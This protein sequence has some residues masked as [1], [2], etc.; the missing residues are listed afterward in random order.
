MLNRNKRLDLARG[1]IMIYIVTIIHGVY[2]LGFGQAFSS[3]LLFEMPIVFII[4]GYAYAIYAKKNPVISLRIYFRYAQTRLSRI[5]IP[6]FVYAL[7]CAIVVSLVQ[8]NIH[9][10]ENLLAWLNPF[11][12]GQGHSISSLSWHLWFI[13]PF[14][15]VTLFLPVVTHKWIRKLPLILGFLLLCFFLYFANWYIEAKFSTVVFYF[16]WAYVGFK[17]GGGLTITSNVLLAVIAIASIMLAIGAIFMDQS[18]NMQLNKFPPNLMFLWFSCIW[19]AIIFMACNHIPANV[20]N[21]LLENK[22]V[23]LFVKNGYSLYLWQGIGYASAK[24]MQSQFELHVVLTWLLAIMFT[25]IL[26]MLFSPLEKI[27]WSFSRA[28]KIG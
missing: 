15:I 4:S 21:Y 16:F 10:Q 1:L 17:L 9:I 12:R 6:Y 3:I 19:I 26:G 18:L 20:I 25:V 7:V 14:L 27:R 11:T 24:A 13:P 22:F 28:R 2:W 5:Y 8:G 23:S